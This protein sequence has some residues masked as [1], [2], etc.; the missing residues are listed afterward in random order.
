MPSIRSTGDV[1]R[2]R[3]AILGALTHGARSGYDL[4]RF[5]EENLGSFWRESYGQIYPILRTLQ[6]EGLVEPAPGEATRRKPYRITDTGRDA[7]ATWL[8]QPVTLEVGRVEI[9]LKL[10]FISRAPSGTAQSHLRAFRAEHAAR[11]ARYDAVAR[12]LDDD[13]ADEPDVRYWRATLAY[14][15]QLS[16]A[17]LAWCDEAQAILQDPASAGGPVE[18]GPVATGG[19]PDGSAP[20]RRRASAAGFT[21]HAP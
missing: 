15:R 12:R 2:S 14:G 11:L 18:P 10:F 6:A 7:L 21:D 9:L 3:Y 5:F 13:L 17:M 20:S 16:R 4:R 19:A 1:N 8:A